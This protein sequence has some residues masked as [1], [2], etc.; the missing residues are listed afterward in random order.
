MMFEAQRLS[1]PLEDDGSDQIMSRRI[2]PAVVITL[3]VATGSSRLST[4][5]A[6]DPPDPKTEQVPTPKDPLFPGFFVSCYCD[7]AP[8]VGML[9]GTYKTY[10]DARKKADALLGQKVAFGTCIK[11]EIDWDDDDGVSHLRIF[12]HGEKSRLLTPEKLAKT[13]KS[14]AADPKYLPVGARTRC[15]EF[16]RDFSRSLLGR[17]VPELQG[18][19]SDQFRNLSE[20]SN[21]KSLKFQDKPQA[22]FREAQALANQ[23]NVVVVVWKNPNP[24]ATNTGHIAVVVPFQGKDKDLHPSSEWEMKVPFIAQ[25]GARLQRQRNEAVFS[26]LPLSEGFGADKKDDMEIFVLRDP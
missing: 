19:A 26:Y 4:A 6:Q 8:T 2:P 10:A 13:A 1:H 5:R 12:R 3:A 24:T 14:L 11:V 18:K 22:A 15:S 16:V 7:D 23:G 9:V 25:A 20:S 21:W 17:D